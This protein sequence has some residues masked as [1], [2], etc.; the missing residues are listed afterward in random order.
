MS[1]EVLQDVENLR[2]NRDKI[3][4]AAQFASVTIEAEPVNVYINLSPAYRSLYQSEAKNK[5]FRRAN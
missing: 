4:A 2:L 3:A 1:N 5:G